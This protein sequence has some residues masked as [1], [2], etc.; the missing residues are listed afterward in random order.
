MAAHPDRI[1][2]DAHAI[3]GDFRDA[4]PVALERIGAPAALV[5]GDFGSANRDA[6][7]VLAAWLG[8]RLVSIVALRAVI[9]TDQPLAAEGLVPMAPPPGIGADRYFMYR[10]DKP[11]V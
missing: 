8:P 9:A 3:I 11:A 7:A 2:D 1:P 5:H 4:I 10:V 6:T